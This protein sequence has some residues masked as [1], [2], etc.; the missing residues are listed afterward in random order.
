M[1]NGYI[2]IRVNRKFKYEHRHVMEQ[3]IGR[4]LD[5]HEHV[6]HIN[7]D[8]TDNRIENLDLMSSTDHGREHFPREI[9]VQ[10]SRKAHAARWGYA[11][12]DV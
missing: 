5:R 4:K 9:A 11:Y 3:F 6:H 12:A 8:K 1:A 7:G 10:R 2:S